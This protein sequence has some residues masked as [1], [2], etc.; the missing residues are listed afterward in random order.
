MADEIK[1]IKIKELPQTTTINNDD[2]FIVSDSVETYK[3]TADD[4][5]NYVF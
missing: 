1:Q 2:I 5:A 3:V 4:I